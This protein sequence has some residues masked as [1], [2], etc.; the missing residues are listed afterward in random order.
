[1]NQ[2]EQPRQRNKGV[3][4]ISEPQ[5]NDKRRW[6]GGEALCLFVSWLLG[7][8]TAALKTFNSLDFCRFIGFFADF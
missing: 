7:C 5:M 1:L 2:I 8:P 4:E 3:P 6:G